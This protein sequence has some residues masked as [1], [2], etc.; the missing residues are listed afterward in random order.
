MNE[1]KNLEI[2][3]IPWAY[4]DKK[5]H[6]RRAVNGCNGCC[7]DKKEGAKFCQMKECCMAHLRPDRTPVI[8]VME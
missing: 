6:A 3:G 1:L 4:G 5:I 2:E 8:F 7:F